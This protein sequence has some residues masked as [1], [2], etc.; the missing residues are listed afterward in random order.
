MSASPRVVMAESSSAQRSGSSAGA[1]R[2]NECELCI[3]KILNLLI[4]IELSRG[5][6]AAKLAHSHC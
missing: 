2:G 5:S 3:S 1:S 4:P 6:I